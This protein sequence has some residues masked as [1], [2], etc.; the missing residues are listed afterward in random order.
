MSL[1]G[2][3]NVDVLFHDVNGTSAI[4]VVSLNNSVEYPDGKVAVITGTAGIAYKSLGTLSQT[5]YRNAAGEAVLMDSVDRIVFIWSGEYPRA[6][7]NAGEAASFQVLSAGG[8]PAVTL[9]PSEM[10]DNVELSGGAGTGAYKIILC[11]RYNP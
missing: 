3:V 4:K 6:L 10:P 5:T 9:F 2:R 11:E 1:D 7:T 8:I